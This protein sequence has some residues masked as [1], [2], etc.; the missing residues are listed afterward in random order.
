[1]L[2]CVLTGPAY[3]YDA[4]G[5]RD[6]GSNTVTT[7]NE[8]SADA[9]WTYS[10]DKEGNL[11]EKDNKSNSSKW[12]YAYNAS[13][14]LTEAKFYNTSGTLVGTVD[15]K[16]D[17]FGEEIEQD[18]MVTGNPTVAT[19]FAYNGWNP[20]MPAGT[21]NSNFMQ[22]AVLNVSGANVTLQ[23]RNID[24]D[25]PGQH[26]GRVDQTGASDPAGAYYDENDRQN[27]V[28]GASR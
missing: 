21:G 17:A 7:G 12:T 20:D 2:A 6:S 26:L 19:K 14:E 9:T 22:W 23:S 10:Y 4:N 8:M 18:A 15:Y 24:G 28:R 27:S 3:G 16:Y 11:K 1:L 5:N 13:N 25:M